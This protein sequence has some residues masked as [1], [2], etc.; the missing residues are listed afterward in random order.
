MIM[1][2]YINYKPANEPVLT[3]KMALIGLFVAFDNFIMDRY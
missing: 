1:K 3:L 2:D